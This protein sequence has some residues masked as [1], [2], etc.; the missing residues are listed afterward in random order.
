MNLEVRRSQNRTDA[1]DEAVCEAIGLNR[2]DHRCH[3]HHR[4]GGRA[5]TAGRLAELMGLTT[6]AVTTVLDRLERAGSPG[7][8]ATRRPPP[9]AR[10]P[11]REGRRGAL[12]LL[13]AD[14][15]PQRGAYSRYSDD[16]LALLLGFLVAGAE[17][18]EEVFA[19][20][21]ARLDGFGPRPERAG[22]STV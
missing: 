10:R 18:H 14:A 2:T 19:E 12:A 15:A 3:R 13:R 20:L 5:I 7:A 6:G 21:R 8:S 4:A 16:E 22:R 1:Y 17:L 9:R 11:D